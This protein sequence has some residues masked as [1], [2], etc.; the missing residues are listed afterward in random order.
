METFPNMRTNRPKYHIT[1]SKGWINDPNGL[2]NF[3]GE[4][5]L[6]AQY[7]PYDTKW[8]PM[9]WLHFKSKDLINWEESGVSLKPD[10]PYDLEFGC[11]SGSSIVVDNKM[12]VYY[13]G[14]NNYKQ[15]QCLAISED[16]EHFKKF[17]G[18]PIL[19]EKDLPKGYQIN[20]F[21]DPK[22]IE[23]NGTYYMLVVSRHV[24]G[25]S[26][27][28]LYS[29]VDLYN[30]K[31]IGV[32]KSF[33][34][35]KLGG[36]VECPDIIF[37]DDKCALIYSLQHRVAKNDPVRFSIW[38][39]VG[40]IDLEKAEFSPLGEERK[41]DDGFDA[42]STQTI[43]VDDKNYLVYWES[44]WEINYPTEVEGYAGQLSLFK[45]VRIE[46]DRLKMSFLKGTHTDVIKGT[47]KGDVGKVK[48][49]NIEILFNKKE[50]VIE[51]SRKHADVEIV[52]EKGKK[53]NHKRIHVKVPNKIKIEYSYDNSCVEL[54]INDGSLFASLLNIKHGDYNIET[55][56]IDLIQ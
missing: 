23:K 37:Q 7:N 46:G 8:G 42:Y 54:S 34:G 14:V 13:T 44:G 53:M 38:Y 33:K 19:S 52:N 6:F 5:H 50:S 28:L 48:I 25:Y 9:H 11:F 30:F 21:R 20:D 47:L 17:K 27:I 49:N 31:F 43:Q 40:K 29:S 51:L 10:A 45:E 18:N 32:L 36:M 2:V 26:S 55:E 39:Q 35:L 22:V 56:N 1:P 24:K 16:G 41:L 4:Y 3:L 15:V 12:Y